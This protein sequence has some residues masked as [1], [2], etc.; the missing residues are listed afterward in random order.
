MRA[1][2][3]LGDYPEVTS[4]D[5][6]VS[7]LQ[8]ASPTNR[9]P[10]VV[11]LRAAIEAFGALGAQGATGSGDAAYL[12]PLLGHASQDVRAAAATALGNLCDPTAI[13]ALRTQF[14]QEASAQV[15]Y[16]ISAALRVLGSCGG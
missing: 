3:D 12:T 13:Q 8:N 14:G 1:I 4:H 16:A 6:L 10:K 9:G 11:L 15:Q 2:R 5:E 7:L